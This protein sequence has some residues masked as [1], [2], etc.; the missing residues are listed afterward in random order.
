[1]SDMPASILATVSVT[2]ALAGALRTQILDGQWL[3]GAPVAE[4]E[5][6][7]RFGVSRPTA[8]TAVRT[9]VHEGLLRQD[10]HRAPYVPR[11]TDADVPDL[12]FVRMPLEIAIVERLC[13]GVPPD[14]LAAAAEQ[15]ERLRGLPAA[16]PTSTFVAADLG[17]HRA[18]A[19]ATQSPRMRRAYATLAG[20]IHL[21]MIQTRQALGRERIVREHSAIQQAIAAGDAGTALRQVREHLTGALGGLTDPAAT[22]P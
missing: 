16:A 4:V 12:F 7:R 17:F 6:A 1:M 14:G 11:L 20:E 8:K 19:D 10:A 21:N 3:P 9:L 18:L 13:A 2:D 15:I 22:R 5:V